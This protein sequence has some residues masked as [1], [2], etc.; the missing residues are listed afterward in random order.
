MKHIRG[1]I[2]VSPDGDLVL[3]LGQNVPAQRLPPEPRQA[4]QVVRINDDVV[5][6]DGRID[7]M[8]GTPAADRW[9]EVL[10]SPR[11]GPPRSGVLPRDRGRSLG[12]NT[13]TSRLG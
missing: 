2:L 5:D 11:Q 7:S 10:T 6:S 8:R 1:R 4:G 13:L 9:I 12:S 3:A